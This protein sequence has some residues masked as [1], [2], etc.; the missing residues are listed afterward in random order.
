MAKPTCVGSPPLGSAI[1]SFF[2]DARKSV[3]VLGG[4]SGFRPV[5]LA[6]SL[7]LASYHLLKSG[8]CSQWVQRTS[9]FCCAKLALGI[10][11]ATITAARV[12]SIH[13]L[14]RFMS[15]P[16]DTREFRNTIG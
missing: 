15:S 13:H 11:T 1:V 12:T 8:F 7:P 6:N 2:R 14:P 5:F 3:M 16:F 9:F 4:S 10:V